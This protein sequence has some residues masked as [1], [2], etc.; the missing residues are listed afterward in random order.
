MDCGIESS[1]LD[2]YREFINDCCEYISSKQ[3]DADLLEQEMD[4]LMMSRYADNFLNEEV[5]AKIV[6]VNK[7]GIYV[8]DTHGLMGLIPMKKGMKVNRYGVLYQG[9]DYRVDDCVSVILK[10]RKSNELIFEFGDSMGKGL[11]KKKEI[12]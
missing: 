11:V 1:K 7:Y 6:F 4:S 3:K 12:K 2:Y 8:K 5:K 10:E 9:C